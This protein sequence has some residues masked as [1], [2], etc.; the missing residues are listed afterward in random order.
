MSAL[1]SWSDIQPMEC[2]M[3]SMMMPIPVVS[4]EPSFALAGTISKRSACSASLALP[5]SRSM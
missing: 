2:A 4:E 3:H 5:V 1:I